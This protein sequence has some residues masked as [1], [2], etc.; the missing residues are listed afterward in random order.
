M[1][2]LAIVSDC[3]ELKKARAADN[4]SFHSHPRLQRM[5]IDEPCDK[6]IMGMVE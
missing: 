2:A 1:L 4:A 6:T 5:I 3:H